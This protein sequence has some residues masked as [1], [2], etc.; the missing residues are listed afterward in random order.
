MQVTSP[1]STTRPE[2]SSLKGTP[3]GGSAAGD[4][5]SA[6][7]GSTFSTSSMRRA[8]TNARVILSTASA[9]VL[10]GMTRNAAYP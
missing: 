7:C 4:S 1:G 3:D 10:S 5:G 6:T 9:A 8:P 2:R